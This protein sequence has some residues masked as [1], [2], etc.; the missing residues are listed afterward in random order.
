MTLSPEQK[1]RVIETMAAMLLEELRDSMG[2][3]FQSLYVVPL[4]VAVNMTGLS[5]ATLRA[6]LPITEMAPGKHGICLAT[7]QKHIAKKT[8]EAG[9]KKKGRKS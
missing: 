9:G 3:T 5:R 8:T 2:G 1:H 7:L 4:T 6:Q